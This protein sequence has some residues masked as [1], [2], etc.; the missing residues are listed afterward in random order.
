M[1]ISP[2]CFFRQTASKLVFL[3]RWL[4]I[5]PPT[6]HAPR[7]HAG[8]VVREQRRRVGA[9]TGRPRPDRRPGERPARL[10]HAELRV[11]TSRCD[12]GGAGRGR[13][14]GVCRRHARRR[15]RS[16]RAAGE[17]ACGLRPAAPDAQPMLRM[18]YATALRPLTR[19]SDPPAG[20]GCLRGAP[21]TGRQRRDLRVPGRPSRARARGACRMRA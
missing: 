11:P 18:R 2:E 16:A 15:D 3:A 7:C 9:G 1:A 4:L 10:R 13:A 20:A 21:R 8:Q 19:L 17:G 14:Q 12:G 6:R 5:L